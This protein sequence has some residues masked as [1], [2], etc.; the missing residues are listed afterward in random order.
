[1][2]ERDYKKNRR[3]YVVTRLED[4]DQEGS[5]RYG[6]NLGEPVYVTFAVSGEIKLKS[7]LW[8]S[9]N[10]TTIDGAPAPGP[11][12][13]TQNTV[14]IRASNVTLRY[15]TI[16][17]QRTDIDI[18]S[19]WILL[20]SDVLVEYCTIF[21]GSDE[22]ISVTRSD[23]VIIQNCII[24]NPM[25]RSHGFG[26]ILSGQDDH[27]INYCLNNL[28]VNCTGRTP[29]V[30]IGNSVIAYNTIYNY[31]HMLSYTTNHKDA[32]ILQVSNTYITGPQTIRDYMFMFPSRPSHITLMLEHNTLDG[33]PAYKVKNPDNGI[34]LSYDASR[35]RFKIVPPD[36]TRLSTKARRKLYHRLDK[37][38]RQL[39]FERFKV[40]GW[41]HPEFGNHLH[42]SQI[43]RTIL[44]QYEARQSYSFPTE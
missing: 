30:G 24:A 31:G 25:K 35:K 43:D 11:V 41:P 20:A 19:V 42:R 26:C 7:R 6:V 16:G 34:I 36:K 8:I 12:I 13:I 44:D 21:G 1:M 9:D 14:Y 39:V 3:V 2:S 33:K 37:L 18:D 4:D 15:L 32:V 5:L 22:I 38:A 23:G 29:N 40:E 28:F 27:S 10:F 17:A